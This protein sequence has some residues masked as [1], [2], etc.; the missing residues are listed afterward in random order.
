MKI[1]LINP[2]T[3]NISLSSPD[4]GLAYLATALQRENHH[5][6][7]LDCV[8]LKM[9]FK[10]F[11]DYIAAHDCDVIGFK[12]FSTDLLSVKKSLLTVRNKR[13][14]VKI[15]L[16]GPHPSYFPEQTLEH[17]E[18]ADFAIR[19]EAEKGLVDLIHYLIHPDAIQREHIPGLIWR[20]E[21]HTKCNAPVFPEELDSLGSPAWDLI[22][23]CAYPFQTS[24]LTESK[25]VA[26]L[27]ITRGCPYQCTFCA[28]RSI[29]GNK[30]RTHSVP[31]IIHEIR[32]LKSNFGINEVCFIDDNFLVFKNMVIDLCKQIIKQQLDIKWS[33]YGIRLDMI[34]K[35]IIDLMEKS[36]CYM[37][38]VGIES[39]S[40]RILDHMKKNLTVELIKEKIKF[41]NDKTHIKI[42]GNFILGYPLEKE[43]DI[44]RTI[45]LTR[46]L[47][48]H[49]ANFFPFHPTPGTEIYKELMTKK[50]IK[51]IDWKLMGLDLRTYVPEEISEKKFKW[52]FFLAFINFYMRPKSIFNVLRA[53]RSPERLK[54]IFDRILTIIK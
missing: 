36:G 27:I 9:T 6:E 52:L 33:C 32:Y 2:I 29:T 13:P 39:G 25:I 54:Y 26:P 20:A 48:L 31:Y 19:G 51:D 16:G 15:I 22:N 10:D 34:D 37:L 11:E 14:D 42:I 35:E 1:L 47:P 4:L 23:P 38:T 49:G 7:I 30:I 12:V 18:E 28:V 8:N 5:V 41:I 17:F 45:R 3:R 44:Y 24:Y 50:K 53:T 43:D 46:E 21:G 40:Q